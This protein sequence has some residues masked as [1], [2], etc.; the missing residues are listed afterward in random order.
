MAR[1]DNALPGFLGAIGGAVTASITSGLTFSRFALRG[2]SDDE[3]VPR[4]LMEMPV[5][6]FTAGAMIVTLSAFVG[7]LLG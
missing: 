2:L 4:R 5:E 3:I 7:A 6:V 1:R